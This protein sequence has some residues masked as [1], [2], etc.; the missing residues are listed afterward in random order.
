MN[1]AR[2]I[3]Q[4]L[5]FHILHPLGLADRLV[6][7]CDRCGRSGGNGPIWWDFSNAVWEA[8]AGNKNGHRHG[9]YC[10]YCFDTMAAEKGIVLMWEPRRHP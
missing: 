9:C 2:L 3:F 5:L 10:I 8:V 4:W 1:K 6:Q 7:H